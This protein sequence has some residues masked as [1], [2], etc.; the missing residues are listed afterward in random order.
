MIKFM[1]SYLLT[2][3]LAFATAT[4]VHAA[5]TKFT[6]VRV[7]G[8][9][10]VD[11]AVTAGTVNCSNVSTTSLTT[12]DLTVTYGIAA[13][14]MATTGLVSLGTNTPYSLKFSSTTVAIPTG[15][16]TALNL[17]AVDNNHIIY[18]STSVAAGGWQKIGAQ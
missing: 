17:L 11:G 1:K 13:S 18:I 14:T 3:L 8:G 6:N 16:P 5:S 2:F 12:A 15:T 10:V 9:L 7:T 4:V